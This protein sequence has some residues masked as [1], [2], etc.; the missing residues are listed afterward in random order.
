MSLLSI[1]NVEVPEMN[2]K[3][4]ESS[5]DPLEFRTSSSIGGHAAVISS[6]DT[7]LV[8]KTWLSAGA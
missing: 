2:V 8:D 1:S 5:A 4:A 6:D 7:L 3:I